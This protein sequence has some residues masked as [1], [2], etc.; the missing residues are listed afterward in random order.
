MPESIFTTR[1]ISKDETEGEDIQ[2]RLAINTT[3]ILDSHDDVHM[4]GIWNQS[5]KVK[6]YI[7]LN[8]EHD[9]S[10]EGIIS[11]GEDVKVSVQ[12]YTWRELG[13]KYKGD[14]EVLQYDANIT[15]DENP[16]MYAKYKAGKVRNH[17]VEMG[18]VRLTMAINDPD[19]KEEFAEWE[20]VRPLIVNG[21]DADERG[22]F[23]PIYEATL[24]RTNN[25]I[26]TV[27]IGSDYYTGGILLDENVT[28]SGAM[29]V[30]I[31]T[32][33]AATYDILSSDYL[34]HVTYTTTAAVTSLTLPTA[35]VIS[36]R[37]IIIKDANGN[38]GTNNITVDTQGSETID[39]QA[40]F[41]LNNNYQTVNI[42]SDG[43]NWFTK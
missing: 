4:N 13:Y 21:K 19:Y 16:Y 30:N 12:T 15:P 28:F 27:V 9:R 5:I 31:T 36:G 7:I 11:E 2:R 37:V 23:F 29:N 6:R 41:I 42:Y 43:S 20:K 26:E 34:L 25:G 35:Q 39:G 8:Q 24:N 40:T 14:T 10:Y 18:Y 22:Y 1:A 3:L 38:A 33:N 17:S 32:I